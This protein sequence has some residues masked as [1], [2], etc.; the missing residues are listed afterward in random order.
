MQIT[1]HDFMDRDRPK[2]PEG[3]LCGSIFVC[4]KDLFDVKKILGLVLGLIFLMLLFKT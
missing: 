4:T 3:A 1:I 2:P